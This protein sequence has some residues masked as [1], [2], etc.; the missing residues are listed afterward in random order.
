M[1]F[2]FATIRMKSATKPLIRY[3]AHVASK[4]KMSWTKKNW[5]MLPQRYGTI[6]WAHSAWNESIHEQKNKT[7]E[8]S[9]C[10][11]SINI[12]IDIPKSITRWSCCFAPKQA[13]LSELQNKS[14]AIIFSV[15]IL[16]SKLLTLSATL[17]SAIL[18]KYTK[19]HHLKA[20]YTAQSREIWCKNS[21]ELLLVFWP[22]AK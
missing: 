22:R 2:S 4:R 7:N 20:I 12:R 5:W 18:N 3:T 9:F 21:K 8:D 16:G 17:I 10:I 15:T 14:L 1:R 19:L 13:G 11:L 6:T